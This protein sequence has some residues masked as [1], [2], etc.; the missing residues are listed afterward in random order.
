MLLWT[1]PFPGQSV[2]NRL[3]IFSGTF[4]ATIQG[5]GL[6]STQS[7]AINSYGVPAWLS[8]SSTNRIG[9][10]EN[11]PAAVTGSVNPSTGVFTASFVVRDTITVKGK[12]TAVARTVPLEGVFLNN[13][14][15]DLGA[16]FFLLPPL[17]SS[18][19]TRSGLGVFSVSPPRSPYP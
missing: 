17:Y 16:G 4:G 12:P 2:A 15:G 6:D 14:G 3:G 9:T 1:P 13:P 5:A 8:L 10:A 7:R 11:A 19:T 18:D